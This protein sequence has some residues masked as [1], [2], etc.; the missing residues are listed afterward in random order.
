VWLLF[1]VVVGEAIICGVCRSAQ[2]VMQVQARNYRVQVPLSPGDMSPVAWGQ[3]TGPRVTG[4]GDQR[5]T[6]LEV[7]AINIT[8]FLGAI[9]YIVYIVLFDGAIVE[10]NSRREK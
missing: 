5:R 4:P 7:N 6:F 8:L 9:C 2:E 3:T 1:V 10:E